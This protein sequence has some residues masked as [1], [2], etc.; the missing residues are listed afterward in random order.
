MGSTCLFITVYGIILKLSSV[1]CTFEI[2]NV[3]MAH[4]GRNKYCTEQ[5]YHYRTV[6]TKVLIII[7]LQCCGQY[8]IVNIRK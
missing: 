3:Q 6:S 2:Q 5:Y 8:S 4:I 7:Y 1:Y